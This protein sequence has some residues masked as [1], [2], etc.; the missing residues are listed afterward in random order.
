MD[1]IL[2]VITGGLEVL[3]HSLLVQFSGPS[4]ATRD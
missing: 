2:T 1:S 4:G 3:Y